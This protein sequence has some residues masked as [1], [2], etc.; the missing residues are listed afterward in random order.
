MP[1]RF[2]LDLTVHSRFLRGCCKSPWQPC[3]TDSLIIRPVFYTLLQSCTILPQV[4]TFNPWR[5][6]T[7]MKHS[8]TTAHSLLPTGHCPNLDDPS[9]CNLT[10]SI[11]SRLSSALGPCRLDLVAVL[12]L[13]RHHSL[14]HLGRRRLPSSRS[15]QS[16]RSNEGPSRESSTIRGR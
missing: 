11:A 14:D 10:R 3:A 13:A 2:G 16:C 15:A 4:L 1:E 9:E 7:N 5:S 6:L 8:V 12:Y